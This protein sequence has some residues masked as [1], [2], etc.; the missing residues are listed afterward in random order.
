MFVGNL[1]AIVV[2][3]TLAVALSIGSRAGAPAGHGLSELRDPA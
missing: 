1:A 3:V 2:S